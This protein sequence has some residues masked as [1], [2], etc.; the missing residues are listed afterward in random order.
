MTKYKANQ[1]TDGA[2]GGRANVILQLSC[3]G[4]RALGRPTEGVK[5]FKTIF[6]TVDEL[7]ETGG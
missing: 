7:K 6:T 3:M 2:E 5:Q 1:K 4:D